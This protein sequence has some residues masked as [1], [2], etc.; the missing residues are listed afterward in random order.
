[1]IRKFGLVIGLLA[2]VFGPAAAQDSILVDPTVSEVVS[3]GRWDS[4]GRSGFYRVILRAGGFEPVSSTLTVQWLVRPGRGE[5]PIIIQSIDVREF[6][7]SSRLDRPRIGG[8]LKGW[9]V[10]VDVTDTRAQPGRSTQRSIDLGPPG[11]V[12]VVRVQ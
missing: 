10:W 12:R 7:G 3:G 11:Q 4:D 8:F 9:R 5:V 2:S 1:M 6:S